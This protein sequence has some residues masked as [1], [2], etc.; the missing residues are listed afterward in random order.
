[1]V[2]KKNKNI[3]VRRKKMKNYRIL[4]IFLFVALFIA[5]GCKVANSPLSP[6]SPAMLNNAVLSGSINGNSSNPININQIAIRVQGTNIFTNPDD[7]GDFRIDG[8]PQGDIVLSIDVIGTL[9]AI[10]IANVQSNE[11]INLE[12][13]VQDNDIVILNNIQ[14]DVLQQAI[15]EFTLDINPDNW[16]VAWANDDEEDEDVL[17]KISGQGFENIVSV[18]MFL[19]VDDVVV[20]TGIS[21]YVQAPEGQFFKAYFKKKEAIGLIPEPISGEFYKILVEV[22]VPD[23]TNPI[24]LYAMIEIHGKKTGEGELTLKINPKKWNVAWITSTEEEDDEYI[25]VKITGQGFMDID[26]L[27]VGMKWISEDGT[28]ESTVLSPDDTELGDNHFMAKFLKKD[29]ILLIPNPISG[30]FHTIIVLINIE[31]FSLSE[32]IEIHGKKSEGAVDF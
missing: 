26:P 18:Q 20:G 5:V 3:W 17:V 8:V 31:P 22:T 15:N 24:K 21:P 7:N 14:R 23:Q 2:E 28:Q 29:A 12:L 4:F 10:P 27:S 32:T 30:E 11:E 13:D 9:S 6:E 16:N 19:T 25:T 1:M